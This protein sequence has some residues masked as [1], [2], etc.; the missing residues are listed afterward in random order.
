[1]RR[2]DETSWGAAVPASRVELQVL[3]LVARGPTHGYELLERARAHS[4]AVGATMS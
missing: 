3:G 4:I 2:P 1:L